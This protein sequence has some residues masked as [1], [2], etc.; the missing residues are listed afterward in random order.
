MPDSR[1]CRCM[2]CTRGRRIVAVIRRGKTS[3]LVNLVRELHNTLLSSE[4]DAS[5]Q[6]AI[7]EGTWPS[8]RH[9]LLESLK[10]CPAVRGAKR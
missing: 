1:T 7:L 9:I 4:E 10:K 2:T 6:R 8:A 3:E 5:V